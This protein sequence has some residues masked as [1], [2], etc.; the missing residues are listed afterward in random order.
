VLDTGTRELRRAG[1][2][3]HLSPKAFE[4]LQALVES[5][6]RPLSKAELRERLWPSTFVH[7]ANLPNLVA[8]VRSA[9]GDDARRARFVRTVHT[10]GYAFSG[11]VSEGAEAP[12]QGGPPPFVYRL[13]A[14]A[15]TATLGDGEH[16]LGR[17]PGSPVEVRSASV[18][19]RHAR[20]RID[21]GEAVLEDL[22][23]RNG[24]FVRGERLTGPARLGDG[25]EFR[26]GTVRLT[27]HVVR[28]PDLSDTA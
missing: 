3:V 10:L 4:L 15:G 9:I 24:T 5:R 17:H 27:F 28:A 6:P 23:S 11:P 8:E 1:E 22:G 26:L 12:D 16:I 14:E 25:D 21:R 2:R 7:E 13:A 18:S 20:L 19:R